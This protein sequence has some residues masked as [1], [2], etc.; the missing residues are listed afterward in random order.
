[1]LLLEYQ[2]R[3]TLVFQTIGIPK[4]LC[5]GIPMVWREPTQWRSGLSLRF[6]VGRLGVYSPFRVIPVDFKKWYRYLPCLAL[7]I[8]GRLWRTSWL[9]RLLC[10]WARHLTGRPIFMWKTGAPDTSEKATP[11]RVRT[12]RPKT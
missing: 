12:Y 3:V 9:A 11:K 5:F 4:S 6:A 2:S 1:M 10:P 8:Y 7:G